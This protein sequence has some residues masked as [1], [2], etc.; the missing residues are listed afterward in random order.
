MADGDNFILGQANAA[1]SET[2]LAAAVA[3]KATLSV[4][5]DGQGD[6]V[7]GTATGTLAQGVY[8]I[9]DHG[10]GVRG[11]SF[12]IVG[13]LGIS[14]HGFGVQGVSFGN[15]AALRGEATA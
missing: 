9:S 2:T 14:N 4:T 7:K 6:G 13:V 12:D 11:D 3:L 8:G 5:N 15:K 10:N 1:S